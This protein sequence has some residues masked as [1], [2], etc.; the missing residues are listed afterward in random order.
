MPIPHAI[1]QPAPSQPCYRQTI[2]VEGW[3]HAGARHQALRR[4]SVHS[5][6]REIGGTTLL[7]PR[8]DVAAALGLPVDTKVG[9][10]LL[11]VIAAADF[12]AG[13]CRIEVRAEF[14]EGGPEL[15]RAVTIEL[16]ANDHTAAPYGDLCNPRKTGMLGREH[17]YSTGFPAQTASP[18]C[19]QLLADY[20]P[21]A[22]TVLDV[23]CGIGAYCEPLRSRGYDW[24][25]C[26]TS[27]HCLREL[28]ARG[29][30]HRA[31]RRGWWPRRG[32]RLPARD[33][34]FDAAIA[35]EVLEHIREPHA[36]LAEIKRV[37]RRRALFSVPNL[38]TLPFLSDRLVAP[39][40]MLEG[41][42]KNFFSRFNLGPLLR[43]H[44]RT[45]E[46]LAYGRQPLASA[47]GL[48]LPYHLFA[49]C[50]R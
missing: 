14:A 17:L 19:V 10:R 8:A 25:G 45:V 13:G 26:E 23:G 7:H 41:D 18:E 28:Q 5:A 44:F 37:T 22:A 30:P 35:I 1:D 50:E 48:P 31:I 46:I 38:E 24:T 15:L 42:H 39:W 29:R 3:V 11:A 21:P 33:G 49:I 36:F 20:L 16:L 27:P 34:E 47:D 4:I 32:Y 40:H 43:Q 6:G 9:F 12:S 2:P